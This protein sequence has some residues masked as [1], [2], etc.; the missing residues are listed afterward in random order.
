[1]K[2]QNYTH[3]RT[4][5][6]SLPERAGRVSA[7]LFHYAGAPRPVPAVTCGYHVRYAAAAARDGLLV[8][9]RGIL[10]PLRL[11]RREQAFAR[12]MAYRIT[13]QQIKGA[14]HEV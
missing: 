11:T 3:T 4:L 8:D 2:T 1:M 12:L 13:Q 14:G 10:P 7:A 5:R 6:E 9:P